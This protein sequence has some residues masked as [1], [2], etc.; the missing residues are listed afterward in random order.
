[1]TPADPAA[2]V[3]D[4]RRAEDRNARVHSLASSRKRLVVV[5]TGLLIAALTAVLVIRAAT[6]PTN[7][8]AALV[9]LGS[10]QTETLGPGTVQSR[11]PVKIGSRI[12][13]TLD[14]V[15]V[16]V[17]DDVRKG[18]VL[19]NLDP[20]ELQ[21]H[22]ASA[23]RA[24]ASAQ[25]EVA[26]A[27]ANAAR[28]SSD[29]TLSRANYE[30]GRALVAPG[31][32]SQAEFDQVKAAIAAAE[33]NE[34][35]ARMAIEA[36]RS[37]LARFVQ[38]QRVADIQLSYAAL[39]SPMDG[40]VTRRALEA[41]STVGPGVTVLEIV[42]ASELWVATL[43]DESQTGWVQPG[44]RAR[45]HLR[46]G[47][48]VPGYVS[49]ITMNADP[50]TRELE[51]DVAFVSRPSRFAVNE[52]ADVTILGEERRGLTVPIDAVSHSPDGDAVFVV[53]GG[54]AALRKVTLGARDARRALIAA[55]LQPGESVVLRSNAMRDG[56]R[57]AV[58]APEGR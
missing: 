20:T 57:V 16:D 52:E 44:Q 5:P 19:A 54:R 3:P 13:G 7:V 40:V 45:I 17:G 56:E 25:E 18:Q 42:N 36:R 48:D 15:L 22:A 43:I 28:A 32:I 23:H 47:A 4:E 14:Q 26:F 2:T 55:G 29:V 27:E 41:G 58:L 39:A 49:R 35:A 8:S 51:V 31:V 24:V 12:T 9:E 21:A 1:M 10:V 33:A 11:Y 38:E 37:D 6:R 46:S 53:D 34:R 50:V 30:R